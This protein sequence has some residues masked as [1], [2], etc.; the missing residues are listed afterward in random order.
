MSC[1][2]ERGGGGIVEAGAG[3]PVPEGRIVHAIVSD[4]ITS[5]KETV[6]SG[7]NR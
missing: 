3:V 2:E 7:K 6:E 5:T 4:K 1:K